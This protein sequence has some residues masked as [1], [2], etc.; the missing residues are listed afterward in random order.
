M[1]APSARPGQPYFERL[2]AQLIEGLFGTLE[3]ATMEFLRTH[4][5]W[6]E[7]AGGMPLMTQGEPG[8]DA[9]MLVSGRL[10]A[11]IRDEQGATR[12]VREMARGEVIGE[13]SMYTGDARSATVVAVR[14]SVLVRLDRAHFAPLLATS[15]AVSIAFTRQVIRRL[16]TEH[17]RRRLAAPVTIAIAAI[18]DGVDLAAFARGLAAELSRR[19]RVRVLDAAAIDGEVG[20]PGLAARSDADSARR[21]ALAIDVQETQH[22]VVLLLADAGLSPW[23]YCCLRHADEVLLVADAT[24]PPRVHPLEA[25][26]AE[27]A[28]PAEAAEILVLLQPV[29][30]AS[31]QGTRTW[32]NRRPVA[33]HVHVRRDY[34]A[35]MARLA[36]LLSRTAVGLVFGGGGARGFA[37]LGVW[38]ALRARGVEIDCV[39]GTSI[40][41]IMAALVAAD[42]S[43]ERAIDIT[44]RAFGENPTGDFNLLPLIS[45]IKGGRVREAI[46]RAL[47]ELT[48]GPIDIEDLWKSCFCVATNYSQAAEQMLVRGDLGRALRATA[49]IP[50]ALPPVVQGGDLLCDGGTFNNFPVDLM[51]QMRGVGHVIG[52]DLGGRNPRHLDFDDVPGSWALLRDRLRPRGKRRYRLPSLTSYLMNITILYSISRQKE[53]RAVTD[54]Y[55]NPPLFKVGLLQWKRFDSIL[56]QGEQHAN[57]VLDALTPAQR[58]ALGMSD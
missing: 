2:L 14:D 45:L 35:D 13:L 39:G 10:R 1:T 19:S 27:R 8:N 40:G 51:R 43:C 29:A 16:Q 24:Q 50:G 47:G 6:V 23:T 49:A 20:V 33:S 54:L 22:D 28:T 44:R 37:H 21:M 4:L 11:Y 12:M 32:L 55:F 30:Q 57:E 9:F 42:P 26:L 34:A 7:L 31:A 53:A 18:S 41:G 17:Q 48:G 36:R 5:Q 38:R 3:P 25:P 52:V 56:R 15:P 58:V 46:E